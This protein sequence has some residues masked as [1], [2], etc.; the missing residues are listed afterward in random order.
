MPTKQKPP[1]KHAV[2]LAN[3]TLSDTRQVAASPEGRRDDIISPKQLKQV[4]KM[5]VHLKRRGEA[6]SSTA[7]R[8]L[9]RVS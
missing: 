9:K 8:L 7:D 2:S 3:R 6:L 5:L 1:K 4:D